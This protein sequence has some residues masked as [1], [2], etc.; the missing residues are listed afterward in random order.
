MDTAGYRK[1]DG[2]QEEIPGGMSNWAA[3]EVP[4]GPSLA[5][6]LGFDG[7]GRGFPGGGSGKEPPANAGDVR[8]AGSFHP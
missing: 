8:D 1:W 5:S 3:S 6:C 2:R 7:E 4:L